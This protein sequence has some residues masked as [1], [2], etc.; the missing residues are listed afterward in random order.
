MLKLR[1]IGGGALTAIAL[2]LSALSLAIAGTAAGAPPQALNVTLQTIVDP[3]VSLTLDHDNAAT[4]IDFG[5]VNPITGTYTQVMNATVKSNSGW[6]LKLF[7]VPTTIAGP[8]LAVVSDLADSTCTKVIPSA[9]LQW[10]LGAGAY[11]QITSTTLAGAQ[12]VST[13]ATA[14]A[15]TALVITYQLVVSWTDVPATYTAIHTYS[16]SQP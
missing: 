13:S 10:K 11:A 15:S 7:K 16:L 4:P 14:T 8:C 1:T 6:T 5:N 3:T 2:S 12:T 9:E